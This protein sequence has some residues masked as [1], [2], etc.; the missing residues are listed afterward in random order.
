V[1]SLEQRISQS[2]HEIE[3]HPHYVRWRDDEQPHD[4]DLVVVN[5]SFTF[6]DV[7]TEKAGLYLAAR[8]DAQARLVLPPQIAVLPSKQNADFRRYSSR[9]ATPPLQ[10]LSTAIADQERKL[11]HVVFG[12]IGD[13]FDDRPVDVEFKVTPFDRIVL[14]PNQSSV[15]IDGSRICVHSTEDE[16]ALWSS[17]TADPAAARLAFDDSARSAFAEAL[18]K[19]QGLATASLR[20][21]RRTSTL[22]GGIMESIVL[23]LRQ[24]LAHYT[25]A[26]GKHARAKTDDTRRVHFN[27]L[28]R[29]AYAFAGDTSTVL[30]LV[31]SV[32]DLKPLIL[33]AT[34]GKHFRLSEALR[35]LPWARL[36][37]KPSLKGYIDLIGDARN[38]AFHNVFPFEKAL[39]FEL[40]DGALTG[41]E[42]RIFSEYGSRAHGNELTF[43]DKELADVM[44][45]FTRARRRPTPSLFWGKNA[46]VMSAMIDLFAAI[47]ET[48][49]N[50]YRS[51]NRG[52]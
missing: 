38:R 46:S 45:S 22:R 28:L 27:E 19:L 3:T 17:V 49:K 18:D 37:R 29:V 21:P 11:G 14:D 16:D 4:G 48:L 9:Q 36:K 7:E 25:T 24:H 23:S 52:T 42:L 6:R 26:L 40:P 20:L 47:D 44:L 13:V 1:T 10:P 8:F 33:W 51:G 41:A 5:N 39:H 50:L 2:L 43:H 35:D 31:S 12:L 30:R 34:I 32:C 15:M